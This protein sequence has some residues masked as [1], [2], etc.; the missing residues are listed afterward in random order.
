MFVYIYIYIFLAHFIFFNILLNF[1]SLLGIRLWDLGMELE[2]KKGLG[3]Y[4]VERKDF[5]TMFRNAREMVK[6]FDVFFFLF[7]DENK[8]NIIKQ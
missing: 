2:Y 7:K 6:E 8:K 1:V 4:G 3:A 5:I